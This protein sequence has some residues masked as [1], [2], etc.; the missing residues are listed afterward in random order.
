MT[1]YLTES[2]IISINEMVIKRYSPNEKI[3]V[4]STSA[5]NMLVNLPEQYV[6]GKKL[7]PTL[8]DKASILFIQLVKKH[9][10]ANGN[11]RTAFFSLVAF[12]KL[13]GYQLVVDTS[14]AVEFTVLIAV[15]SLNDQQIEQTKRWIIEHTQPL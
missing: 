3:E 7:Y 13:N 11:K 9:I 2:H 15:D 5:L 12:L 14:E 4:M 6:F 10:F 1:V 8:W